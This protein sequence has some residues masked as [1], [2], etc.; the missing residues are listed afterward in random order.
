MGNP[1][2]DMRLKQDAYWE[3][4]RKQLTVYGTWNSSYSRKQNDW[5][6]ALE[7]MVSGSVDV[8]PLVTQRFPLRDCA[9]AFDLLKDKSQF[10]CRVMFINE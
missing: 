1:I 2:S 3:I 5:R 4:L 6:L 9:K 10:S 7:A 8:K